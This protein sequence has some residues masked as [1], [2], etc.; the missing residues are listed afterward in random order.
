GRGS[1]NLVEFAYFPA[2]DV[3]QP[4]I[5]QVVV[6]T[7][8]VFLYNHDNLLELTPGDLFHIWMVYEG[9][10]RKLTT[11]TQRNGSSYGSPQEINVPTNFDFRVGS[12]S[13][14]SYSDAQA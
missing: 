1:P 5:S 10:N 3:F 7:N 14:S 6:S 2:F 11:T 13:I 8:S 4:T 9:T 12:V